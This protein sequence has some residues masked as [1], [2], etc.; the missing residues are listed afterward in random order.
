V[1]GVTVDSIITALPTPNP[2]V[3]PLVLGRRAERGSAGPN[4]SAPSAAFTGYVDNVAFWSTPLPAAVLHEQLAVAG[5]ARDSDFVIDF[6]ASA[7]SGGPRLIQAAVGRRDAVHRLEAA[8]NAGTVELMWESQDRLT[9]A[10]VV[11]RSYDGSAF[12]EIGRVSPTGNLAGQYSFVDR[13]AV[14]EVVFYRIS[15]RFVSGGARSSA[16]IKI[17][18][19]DLMETP[20][21]DASSLKVWNFPNPF[22]ESTSIHYE[23]SEAGQV[24]LSV[25]DLSGQPVATLVDAGHRAG[26]YEVAFTAPALSAGTYFVRLQV[27]DQIASHKLLL[28]K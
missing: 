18:L 16:T 17:G 21:V 23:L 27:G 1:D 22:R 2:R 11:E 5:S 28:I 25:W 19:A 8:I 4:A 15:Q 10:F 26:S 13:S 7:V 20:D 14:G 6:E 24:E 3:A 9:E 12:T